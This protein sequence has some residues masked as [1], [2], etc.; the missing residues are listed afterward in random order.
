MDESSSSD[1]DM[2]KKIQ[3]RFGYPTLIGAHLS[4]ISDQLGAFLADLEQARENLDADL[5]FSG[6]DED[7][8]LDW[9]VRQ[10]ID[11]AIGNV[12]IASQLVDQAQQA[13]VSV[14]P[15]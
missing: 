6:I 14:F 1:L 11:N 13:I 15:T 12:R 2:W 7:T 5:K 10:S 4:P 3:E 8:D 9:R